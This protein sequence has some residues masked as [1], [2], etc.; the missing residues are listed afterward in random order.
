MEVDEL[1]QGPEEAELEAAVPD[2]AVPEEAELGPRG[3]HLE[4]RW[5]LGPRWQATV[6][7]GYERYSDDIADSPIAR[8]DYEVEAGVTLT[9]RF[10]SAV[11]RRGLAAVGPEVA[12]RHA[13][14]R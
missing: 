12:T 11:G 4:G 2:E 14:V 13:A 6:E 7:A 10:G 1:P 3:L 5:S 9:W 8:E